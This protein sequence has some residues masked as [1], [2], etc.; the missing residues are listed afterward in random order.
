MFRLALAIAFFSGGSLHAPAAAQPLTPA[1][2]AALARA[3]AATVVTEILPD[4]R[5]GPVDLIS[6]TSRFDSLVV[7]EMVASGRFTRPLAE[8]TQT[9]QVGTRG[10]VMVEDTPAVMIEITRCEGHGER[11]NCWS[12]LEMYWFAREQ[13]RWRAMPAASPTGSAR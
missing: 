11:L 5:G 12:S 9:V 8:R 10:L 2:S 3:A 13:G 7:R 6:P 4:T 1:D